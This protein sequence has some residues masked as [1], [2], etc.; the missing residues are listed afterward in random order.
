[1]SEHMK[2]R[3]FLGLFAAACGIGAVAP[4]L[5]RLLSRQSRPAPSYFVYSGGK[6]EGPFD[7]QKALEQQ[8]KMIGEMSRRMADQ[9]YGLNR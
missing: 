8:H 4:G 7:R 5:T 1:M 6:V 9:F 2:R 3:R